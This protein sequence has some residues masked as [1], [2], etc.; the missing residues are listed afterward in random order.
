M[1][2]IKRNLNGKDYKVE[3]GLISRIK[4]ADDGRGEYS[5]TYVQINL[6]KST[7]IIWGDYHCSIGR[8]N[9]QEYHDPDIIT[10]GYYADKR[11]SLS[12]LADALIYS[13]AT[14]G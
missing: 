7:G 5:S 2:T 4:N 10:L 1:K 8:N 14:R 13:G 6:E 11:F 9:W 12:D 3:S